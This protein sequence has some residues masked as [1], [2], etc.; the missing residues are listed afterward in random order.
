MVYLNGAYLP[1]EKASISP[2]DRG[3][4]FGDGV[5]EVIP[6]YDGQMF[7]LDAHLE[8][9]RR[10]LSAIRLPDPMPDG[11]WRAM[12]QR[13]LQENPGAD[14]SVYLQ[15]T[16]GKAARDHAFPAQT[17]ATVFAMVSPLAAQDPAVAETGVSAISVPDQRWGRCDIKSVALLANVL[18]RQQAAEQAAVE[19]ILLRDGLLTEGAASN[20]FVVRDGVVR[21][22]A[23]GP[24][25]L[26]GITRAFV[27]EVLRAGRQDCREEPITEADLRAADEIWL[28]SSTKEVL[29]VTRLD[30]RPVGTGRPGPVWRKALERYRQARVR[31]TRG[32]GLE[33][34]HG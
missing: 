22:T 8:R 26:P 1:P 28:T 29:P 16:R 27:L 5:Y 14:R 12:L 23:L 11:G 2:M 20:V 7:L 10:S 30:G 19:A 31:A 6:S 24:A 25:I 33:I 32:P 21:T 17:A 13:L 34:H 4:L 3:F 15:V 9:L 18:A